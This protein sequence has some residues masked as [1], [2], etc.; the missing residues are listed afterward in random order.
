MII[1]LFITT[2]TGF[3]QVF[4][5]DM[6]NETT[7][8]FPGKWDV[9]NGTAM[10]N[11][12]PTGEK[13]VEIDHLSII[14][15]IVNGK[16]DGYLGSEF[17]ASFKVYFNEEQY[18]GRQEYLIRLWDGNN[19]KSDDMRMMPIN[20]KRHGASTAYF[21]PKQKN[22]SKYFPTNT[23]ENGYDPN[24]KTF[25]GMWRTIK[26]TYQGESLSLF[27]DDVPVF[28]IPKIPLE[29]SMISLG[30][31]EKMRQSF[32]YFT[33]FRDVVV[34]NSANPEPTQLGCDALRMELIDGKWAI[35]SGSGNLEGMVVNLKGNVGLVSETGNSNY[36]FVEH[37]WKDIKPFDDNAYEFQHTDED[38]MVSAG[39]IER[40]NIDEIRVSYGN[41]NEDAKSHV[42]RRIRKYHDGAIIGSNNGGNDDNSG[43]G[44][45]P[46]TI[47]MDI[48]EA[49]IVLENGPSEIDYVVDH[50]I[51]IH[52][53]GGLVIPKGVVI[54]FSE[55]GGIGIYNGGYLRTEGGYDEPV[56]LVAQEFNTGNW[57]GIHFEGNNYLNELKGT[58]IDRA[59]GKYV[60]CCYPKAA[61][62]LKDADIALY[63]IKISNSG[64]CGIYNKSNN[65]IIFDGGIEYENN[66][67]GDLCIE[68]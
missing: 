50:V 7:G 6:M 20:V 67:D 25:A 1:T 28:V 17:T 59:G 30:C 14:R 11:V 64:G 13:A 57:R 27:I 66:Q 32:D 58:I 63:S 65:S 18:L 44:E 29:P 23:P 12:S 2:Y 42:W 39:I 10:V 55:Q 4:Q 47:P 60:Y 8:T 31:I 45:W 68:E 33:A 22:V 19:Y 38:G 40:Y 15:P 52:D 62:V 34:H 48:S 54:A 16:K 61:I 51:D 46:R 35:E 49:E 53:D 3:S 37:I 24:T 9:V 36:E 21:D 41:T 56:K 5:D 26:I 43:N